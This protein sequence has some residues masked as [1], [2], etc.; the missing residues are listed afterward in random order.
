MKSCFFLILSCL[1][2]FLSAQHYS[3]ELKSGNHD[4]IIA[5]SYDRQKNELIALDK[6]GFIVCWN[7]SNYTI[8]S[9]FQLPPEG[10]YTDS[11]KQMLGKYEVQAFDSIITVTYPNNL[12]NYNNGERLV[13]LYH[14][15]TGK[16]IMQTPLAKISNVIFTKDATM[17][18]AIATTVK[19]N[20]HE[21]LQEATLTG[22]DRNNKANSV[23]L[24]EVPTCMLADEKT[25]RLAIGYRY[26]TVEIRDLKTFALIKTFNDFENDREKKI[27]QLLFIPKSNQVAYT[28]ENNGKIIVR[29]FASGAITV[30]EQLEDV[31]YRLAISPSGRYLTALRSNF[32]E[33]HWKD[34][35][36]KTTDKKTILD[37][38]KVPGLF[39][40]EVFFLN[41]D[42]LIGAGR[43][44]LTSDNIKTSGVGNTGAWL[45]LIDTRRYIGSANLNITTSSAWMEG[46]GTKMLKPGTLTSVVH[47]YSDEFIYTDPVR[48]SI[49][50]GKLTE[51]TEQLN[52]YLT[53]K[54]N[55]SIYTYSLNRVGSS[56]AADF[57]NPVIAATLFNG[58]KNASG[59]DTFFLSYLDLV[60]DSIIKAT[61]LELP[62][63]DAY[64]YDL[65]GVLFKQGLSFFTHRFE[66]ASGNRTTELV[67]FNDAGKKVFTDTIVENFSNKTIVVSPDQQYYAYQPSPSALIVRSVEDH[68]VVHR[69]NTGFSKYH[70][71]VTGYANPA[72]V[73]ANPNILVHEISATQNNNPLFCLMATDVSAKTSDTLFTF[74]LRPQ[75]YEIDSTAS[76]VSLV[77]NYDFT[78]SAF[79]NTEVVQNAALQSFKPLYKP[80]VL[81]YSVKEKDIVQ[82][83]HTGKDAISSVVLKNNWLTV[84]HYNGQFSYINMQNKQQRLSH[85]LDGES[86]ALVTDSFYYAS[87]NMLPLLNIRTTQGSFTASQADVFLNK[88]HEVLK[89]FNK[90]GN[91]LIKPYEM[92][93][94]KR[95]SQR[96][97]PN[98]TIANM[99]VAN[100]AGATKGVQQQIIYTEKRNIDLPFVIPGTSG[101]TI[102]RVI[103]NG[104]PVSLFRGAELK[105]VISSKKLSFEL[106][107]GENF[108]TILGETAAGNQLEPVKYYY[109]YEP[110]RYVAPK[111]FFFAAGVSN[112]KDSTYNLKYAAKD[113][114]DIF[115]A[116]R[117]KV[118]D[119]I[120]S[121]I[122][123]DQQ[124]TRKNIE[125]WANQI[126][127]AGVDD[128]VILYFAGHGLLDAKNN[129]YYAV[130][131]MDFNRPDKNGISYEDLLNLLNKS[132]SRKKVLLLDACHSG[133]FDRSVAE[134]M[135]QP[136]SVND[137]KIVSNERSTIKGARPVYSERQ[138]FVLM[139]QVFADL[140]ADIGIDVIAASLGNSYALEQETLQNGL[141]TYA[142]IRAVGLGMAAGGTNET[143]TINMEQVKRYVNQEVIRLSRG[144]QVPSIRA[145][146]IQSSSIE[147][148]YS[149]KYDEAF[150]K[151]LERYK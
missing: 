79:T 37:H 30:S 97:L 76:T 47:G 41:D 144:E 146:S 108:I 113:A 135:I 84:L 17:I 56:S 52:Y 89:F 123:T 106:S 50:A 150:N 118:A 65:R 71:D 57:S 102:L 48:L 13:D 9:K 14:R 148:H 85:I 11:R 60:A 83:I 54:F 29:D 107:R 23:A 81:L 115:Q 25:N 74:S 58:N 125:R 66:N 86:Q 132:V 20:Y 72:F 61:R 114:G 133:A 116:F 22:I 53:N 51:K 40:S 35:Q 8:I 55:R 142:M 140:S 111:L 4:D 127:K 134:K 100:K 6:L 3:I 137:A 151:F 2:Q 124:V 12:Y 129:F 110:E 92:A 82:A 75:V 18:T 117:Y 16:F 131:D 39:L 64:F 1:T 119:T 93:Y 109:H 147:F 62:N 63:K 126:N 96:A 42:L 80:T 120:I 145:S 68:S 43:N 24:S 90:Q 32:M 70:Y 105:K 128:I 91:D 73:H 31:N 49:R 138:A 121:E 101:I 141:F 78:D 95:L 136:V 34:L 99:L 98:E 103:L 143:Q 26:G 44:S 27:S 28:V 19:Q 7:M 36:K 46:Y 77:Y 67:I 104:Q 69:I 21:V 45:G 130:H 112:Y 88:P 94:Q 15:R 5:A 149:W 87:H 59:S 122:L 38:R 10:P 33:L 139:N